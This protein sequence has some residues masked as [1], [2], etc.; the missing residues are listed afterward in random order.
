MVRA[1]NAL[2]RSPIGFFS[3]RGLFL[4]I[5]AHDL[6]GKREPANQGVGAYLQYLVI[7]RTFAGRIIRYS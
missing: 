1:N 7:Y 5:S 6:I 3:S 2:I 4:G